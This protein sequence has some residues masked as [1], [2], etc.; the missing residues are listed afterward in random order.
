MHVQQKT[1]E[2]IR[3][4]SDSHDIFLAVA[5]KQQE[6]QVKASGVIE[7]IEVVGDD[8]KGSGS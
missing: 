7:E 5:W 4:K 2:L 6:K 3:N 1:E 8:K